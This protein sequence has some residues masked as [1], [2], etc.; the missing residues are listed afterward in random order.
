[1]PDLSRWVLDN[2]HAQTA[3]KS[4][5]ARNKLLCGTRFW[6]VQAA[7]A[8][9]PPADLSHRPAQTHRNPRYPTAPQSQN[10]EIPAPRHQNSRD[11]R[12]ND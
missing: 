1:M 2:T 4:F 7:H 12:H 6:S 3:E 5:P 11:G 10:L 8:G 9:S